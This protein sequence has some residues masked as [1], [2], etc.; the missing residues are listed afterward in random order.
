MEHEINKNVYKVGIYVRESRDEKDENLETI[1]TQRDLLID[2]VIGKKLGEIVKIYLDDNVS[3][4]VFERKGIELLKEDVTSDKI[5]MLI[6]KD[7]SRLG[8]NNAKTL[9]F[10]DYLEEYGV[11]VLTYDGRYDSIKDNDTVG[12]D[13]WY[14]ERYIR[15]IS[16][17]IR[18][19]L[20]F[21]I[22]KGEYIGHAPYGYIKSAEHKNRLSVDDTT[23]P[24]VKQIYSLYMEG[25]GYQYIAKYL[26]DKGYPPPAAR[27]FST[28]GN[29]TNGLSG[30]WNAVAVQRIL[31]NRVYI[32]DTVQGVSEKISF[33]SKKTRRLPMT[34]WV[35]T[36]NT[37]E[38]IISRTDFEKVQKIRA[39]KRIAS[40]A[41]KGM[42][43][44]LK[45]LIYCGECG[46]MMFARK[47]KNRPMGYICGNY[48]NG[49]KKAC[50]SHYINESI[51]EKI[52][53]E[54]ILKQLKQKEMKK[55]LIERLNNE[56]F[57]ENDS[58]N[59]KE[60]LR[61]QL[62]IKKRQQDTLYMDR[63]EGR[64]SN[65][66]FSRMNSVL[67]SSLNF[68]NVEIEDIEQKQ[69]RCKVSEDII[70]EIIDDILCNGLNNEIARLVIDK[71]IITD[72]EEDSKNSLNNCKGS[73][74]INYKF[75][76][77]Y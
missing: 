11:R 74:I 50:S 38:P 48:A 6:L 61:Y 45:G 14:N 42:I 23:A 64:I 5:N 7:L 71:I 75:N 16:R 60:K 13:T 2:F 19:N 3:G 29:I 70:Q 44:L 34:S 68:I 52:I 46:S 77:Q 66:L 31:C 40:G 37:H 73:I 18:A 55:I 56:Y 15:D 25:F 63:L 41:H 26:S 27:K 32:G 17:K 28:S 53:I 51:I 8:R 22:S 9:Q 47:R 35:I 43:H 4:S 67:E 20:R 39:G 49:G 72:I 24:V 12:I 65:E 33:K 58:K 30:K 62:M 1:E 54:D 76:N 10:L 57:V 69:S 21:K 59:R 36:R